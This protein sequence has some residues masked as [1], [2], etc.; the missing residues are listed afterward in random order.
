MRAIS[1]S[2]WH[3]FASQSSAPS[4]SARTRWATVDGPLQT[5]TG[6]A[7]SAV[8]TCS[9][10][11]QPDAPSTARS[12]DERAEPQRDQ[13]LDRHRAGQH[14]LLPAARTDALLEDVEEA[15]V[16]VDDG[17]AERSGARSRAWTRRA[18]GPEPHWTSCDEC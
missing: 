6:S 1:S 7:G 18:D 3:G 4:R 9:R 12:I 14:A 15:A 2:G 10:Y 17:E 8:H 5:T 16:A 11:A 13:L